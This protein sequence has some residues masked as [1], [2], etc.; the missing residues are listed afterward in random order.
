MSLIKEVG[1]IMLVAKTIVLI[2]IIFCSFALNANENKT[3]YRLILTSVT[4]LEKEVFDIQRDVVSLNNSVL[5]NAQLNQQLLSLEIKVEFIKD[6]LIRSSISGEEVN[7]LESK[8]S[9]LELEVKK[10]IT[11]KIKNVVEGNSKESELKWRSADAIL[12]SEVLLNA[13]QNSFSQQLGL[14]SVLFSVFGLATGAAIYALNV[15]NK[16]AIDTQISTYKTTFKTALEGSQ[17][18]HQNSID[19]ESYKRSLVYKNIAISIYQTRFLGGSTASYITLQGDAEEENTTTSS[20]SVLL[21]VIKIQYFSI[22]QVQKVTN[23]FEK[24]RSLYSESCLDLVYYICE[25]SK[26]G[27]LLQSKKNEAIRLLGESNRFESDWVK[28]QMHKNKGNNRALFRRFIEYSDSKKFASI[29]LGI[30][31]QSVTNQVIS[32]IKSNALLLFQAFPEIDRTDFD[33]VFEDLKSDLEAIY[34]DSLS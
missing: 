15:F 4:N 13:S 10:T 2:A 25:F 17:K 28:W 22:E 16:K 32:D 3:E 8:L 5:S 14:L 23:K 33:S 34:D 11:E 26:L 6:R 12:K 7:N 9:L 24:A 20:P 19:E 21:E 30:E 18:E 27:T 29:L 31:S 1:S